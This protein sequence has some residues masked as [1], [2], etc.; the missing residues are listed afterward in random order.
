MDFR[1]TARQEE[2]K[3]SARGL[4]EFV[5]KY[6]MDCEENNGLP[7]QAHAEIRDAVLDSGLQAVNMPAEWGGAGLSILEQATV[8]EELGRLTGALW[9]MVWRPAN[10]L[11]FCTPEQRERYLVP[12][13]RGRRRDCYAVTEPEAGSDPQNLK[14]TAT[15]TA[16]GWVL[17]GEKWFVTV[18][19]HA[20]FMIVLAAAG[21]EGAPTLFLVDKETPGIEMTRVPRFMHTFVYEHPEFTFTDVHVPEDAVLGGIGKGYDITRSWFTEERLMIAAR[22]TGAAERALELARDWAIE[23]RQFGSPIADFQLIQG[24]LADCAVDIAVNRAYTHQVAWEVDAG[25]SDRKTLHAK[26]AIAK[27]SASE[28]AGRVIDRCVQIFGG[29]GYDRSYPVER[30]YRELRV[31]RIWEGT[32]EIQR[33]IIAGELVK[34]GTGVL[35]MPSA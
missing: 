1:L 31:D 24:M 3:S 30:L 11:R 34:R 28:A 16:D 14:T 8:Q 33:L 17:N 9:D 12:V 22:T 13:I 21:E 32:S 25:L 29:R 27:L 15:R 18:G 19:D 20:D 10:A 5:M 4:T 23:R 6:E 26:A 2:L 7:P 35:Q